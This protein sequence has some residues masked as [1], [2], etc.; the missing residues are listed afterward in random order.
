MERRSNA[1]D[2]KAATNTTAYM[3]RVKAGR[4]NWRPE[5]D[6]AGRLLIRCHLDA[7]KKTI[8]DRLGEPPPSIPTPTE[9]RAAKAAGLRGMARFSRSE[10][11]R[12][13]APMGKELLRIAKSLEDQAKKLDQD[14]SD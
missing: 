3:N 8:R 4:G 14:D 1:K 2:I 11:A 13:S 9:A 10:V 7:E 12:T 6:S 5:K